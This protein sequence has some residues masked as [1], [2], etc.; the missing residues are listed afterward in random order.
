MELGLEPTVVDAAK[1]S[2]MVH[3]KALVA[4]GADVNAS[5]HSVSWNLAY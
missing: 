5:D 1:R 3:L 4:E 2:D